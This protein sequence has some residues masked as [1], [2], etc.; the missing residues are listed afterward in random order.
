M[1]NVNIEKMI[2][3]CGCD[4]VSIF[5]HM[6]VDDMK[7]ISLVSICY[8][9]PYCF[10]VTEQHKKY[11]PGLHLNEQSLLHLLQLSCRMRLLLNMQ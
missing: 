2:N 1:Q 8:R 6:Y 10:V 7:C 5:I 11:G 9:Y 3:L 4:S